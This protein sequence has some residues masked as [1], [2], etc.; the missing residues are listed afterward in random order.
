MFVTQ[1]RRKRQDGSEYRYWVLKRVVWDKKLKKNR[2]EYV[3]YIGPGAKPVLSLSKAKAICK[4]TGLTLHHLDSVKR[5]K[6]T[7]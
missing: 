7:D 1:H 2:Q 3:S 6:I 5:L 4:K